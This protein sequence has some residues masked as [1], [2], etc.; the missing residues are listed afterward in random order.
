M[1]VP[2]TVGLKPHSTQGGT[3][4]AGFLITFIGAILFS[5]KAVMVKVAFKNTPMDALTLLMLRMAWSF[6][7]YFVAAW[8]VGVK[9]D[10]QPLTKKQW[11]TII[12]LGLFGYY[13][14]SLF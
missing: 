7:F 4:L 8:M 6:P 2:Q 10:Q 5:T 1:S 3:N 11:M 14:S 13:L 9:K 12:F